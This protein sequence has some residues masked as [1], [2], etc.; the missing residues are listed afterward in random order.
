MTVEAATYISEL[1]TSYPEAGSP[2]QD[3]DNHI[4]LHK[5]V[6][7]NSF[8]NVS[9]PVTATHTELSLLAGAT[10]TVKTTASAPVSGEWVHMSSVNVSTAAT[11]IDFV[12]GSGSVIIGPTYDQYQIVMIGFGLSTGR[13]AQL[14][15]TSNAGT[16]WST[17]GIS[18]IY[19]K[20]VNTTQTPGQTTNLGYFPI[21]CDQAGVN[22]Q[23]LANSMFANITL[24]MHP[25]NADML[26]VASDWVHSAGA[27]GG[28]A[29]GIIDQSG[30]VNGFRIRYNDAS[31]F[32]L[33]GGIV[34]LYGRKT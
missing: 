17:A 13:T 23:L 7:K 30:D 19:M 8:P 18:S 3:V 20:Q 12:N 4:R 27:Y 6:H 29:K 10:G 16:T 1:N 15:T 5:T 26:Y 33:P 34:R 2:Y 21:C 11:A 28:W 9:G 24:T 14:L 31:A 25:S 32:A 22:A